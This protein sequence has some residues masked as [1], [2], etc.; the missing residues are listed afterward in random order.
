MI[1][2]YEG[3]DGSG[4]SIKSLQDAE[5]MGCSCIRNPISWKDKD[6]Y[7]QW[8]NFFEQYKDK[9]VCVDRSFISNPVY[10]Q[11]AKE[12]ITFTEEQFKTLLQYEFTLI[13][14]ES[15]TEYEDAT[16]RGEENLKTREDYDKVKSLYRNLVKKISKYRPVY[17]YNWRTNEYKYLTFSDLS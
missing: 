8:L 17:M 14:C 13:Y 9:D 5:T 3:V 12:D 16:S 1:Y 7:Q 11:W 10:K 15:G 6:A 4:K 2:I